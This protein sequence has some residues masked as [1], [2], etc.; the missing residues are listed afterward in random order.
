MDAISTYTLIVEHR[1][2][3]LTNGN[4]IDDFNLLYSNQNVLRVELDEDYTKGAILLAVH[5]ECSSFKR[6]MRGGRNW[7]PAL[8][9]HY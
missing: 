8:C 4:I 2:A 3:M 9:V 5:N 1:F 7:F 6:N